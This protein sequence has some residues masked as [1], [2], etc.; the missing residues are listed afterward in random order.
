MYGTVAQ[1]KVILSL[2]QAETE[3]IQ[4]ESSFKI[5]AKNP[6]STAFGMAQFLK[7]TRN[8]YAK[9]FGYNPDTTNPFEQIRMFRSYVKDRYGT[10]ENA[11]SFHK[12][13]NWY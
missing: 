4:R 7:S 9:K 2:S 11:L 10:A 6:T 12:K 1:K 5:D 8:N 13:M 3:L